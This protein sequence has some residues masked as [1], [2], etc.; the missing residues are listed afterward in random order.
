MNLTQEIEQIVGVLNNANNVFVITG[1]GMSAD[2]GVPTY[3]GVGGLY[4]NKDTEDGLPIEKALSGSVFRKQPELTWK[5]LGQ[6]ENATRGAVHNRG[7]EILA[8]METLFERLWVLTQ[9]IDGFHSSAGSS[10]VIEIHGNLRV[11][12]CTKCEHRFSLE[13]YSEISIPPLCGKCEA[14]MRPEVVLFEEQLPSQELEI[15]DREVRRGFDAVISIG[16]SSHFPYIVQP[17]IYAKQTGVFTVE[18]NPGK[19]TLSNVVDVKLPI[20]AADALEMIWEAL[21]KS[22]LKNSL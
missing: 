14:I 8:K 18:I 12:K 22:K 1:A 7:H 9:N 10:D 21:D 13:D 16:T 3:R 2:S 4:E 11:L 19:T 6:I 20:G 17:V 5:Y 15:L